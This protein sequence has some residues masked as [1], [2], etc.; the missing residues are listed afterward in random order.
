MTAGQARRRWI[1]LGSLLALTAVASLWLEDDGDEGAGVVAQ[2]KADVPPA[3]RR[4]A[5]TEVLAL[6]ALRRPPASDKPED[7]FAA[8]SWYVPPPPP[9]AG[10]P[11]AP[12]A[13]PLPFAYMGRM[14]EDGTTT[15][16][17]TK[18]DRNYAA[19]VGDTL[20]GTYRVDD[21]DAGSVTLTYLPLNTQQTLA[22]GSAR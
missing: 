15:V 2:A 17:L 21:I 5:A 18:Q 8:K 4:P 3:A 6:S 7:A 12:T 16:F 11:P 10:P 22:M 14:V 13:P 20:D 19:K 9:K 1:V